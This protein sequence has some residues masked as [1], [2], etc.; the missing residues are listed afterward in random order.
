MS[1]AKRSMINDAV[2]TPSSALR[3]RGAAAVIAI[4]LA[5]VFGV[6]AATTPTW[7]VAID[8]SASE[9][10][11]SLGMHGFF[12]VVTRL[13]SIGV[14]LAFAAI[15]TAVLWRRCRPFAYTVLIMIAIGII[16][17]VV[18]KLAVDRARPLNPLVGTGLGSFPSGHVIIAVMVLG[19]APPI[20][21]IVTQSRAWFRVAGALL[22]IGVPLVAISRV[23]LGAHWPSDVV[24][25]I[26]I[27]VALLLTAEYIASTLLVHT[28]GT[29]CALHRSPEAKQGSDF[30]GSDADRRSG[31][32]PPRPGG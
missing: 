23:N 10:V 16:I 3:N 11:R 21:L 32:E 5:I 31:E 27:G 30:V 17:D 4:A 19:L 14:V 29:E 12:L 6:L 22:L 2:P 1:A 8:L 20:V 9:W 13:G 26:F 15:A 25:S 7:L 28:D 24:G 18:V